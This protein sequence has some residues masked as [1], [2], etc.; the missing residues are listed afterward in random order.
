M[1][2]QKWCGES[3]KENAQMHGAEVTQGL[4]TC[5]NLHDDCPLGMPPNSQ[6][7]NTINN[8]EYSLADCQCDT[9]FHNCLKLDGGWSAELV[10]QLFFN[11][12]AVP[13]VEI[14]PGTN[15]DEPSVGK[16]DV[17]QL[18]YITGDDEYEDEEKGG[19]GHD[20]GRGGYGRSGSTRA[21]IVDDKRP[22]AKLKKPA[23]F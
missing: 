10:G 11:V 23:W 7:W 15:L 12:L 21:K 14:E 8:S 9:L 6:K 3:A 19:G 17:G 2:G 13:C 5:C 22:G 20:K 16:N 4:E 18:D 1:W